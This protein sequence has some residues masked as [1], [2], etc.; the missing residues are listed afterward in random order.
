MKR[1]ML[2]FMAFIL[3]AGCMGTAFRVSAR[4]EDSF[5]D[6]DDF[7]SDDDD[8]FFEEEDDG[9]ERPFDILRDP[10]AANDLIDFGIEFFT[11]GDYVYCLSEDGE[12]A[13]TMGYTG[14]ESRVVV[15][16]TLDGHP[17]TAI[18]EHTFNN[19]DFLEEVVLPD[20]IT[21][22]GNGAFMFSG[23]KS[24]VIP[25]GVTALNEACFCGCTSLSSVEI[26]TTVE[27]VGN[28]AFLACTQLESISFGDSLQVIGTGAF[29]KCAELRSVTIPG[30]VEIGTD[31]FAE[32]PEDMA[33]D[34]V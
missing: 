33:I 16:E 15:P 22:I 25:E 9:E 10:F 34:Q 2:V 8:E 29:Q 23:L 31:A 3:L 4:A 1:F 12:G 20:G 11:C 24:I 17:V 14:S 6:D 7:F 21:F 18:G 13:Y 28:F 30:S 27:T 32:C 19:K 26:P 5:E